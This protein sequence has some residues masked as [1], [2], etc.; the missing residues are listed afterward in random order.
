MS[1]PSFPIL[2]V[3]FLLSLSGCLESDE[4]LKI[5]FCLFFTGWEEGVLTAELFF[6]IGVFWGIFSD[7]KSCYFVV[8]SNSQLS[9]D[10]VFSFSQ[11]FF[12]LIV[13]QDPNN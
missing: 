3:S 6:S 4:G 9:C 11:H 8:V 5:C 7:R 2:V 12:F 1:P 13:C 10:V